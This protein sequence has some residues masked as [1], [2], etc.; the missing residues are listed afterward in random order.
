MQSTIMMKFVI[1]SAVAIQG[2]KKDSSDQEPGQ[3][4]LQESKTYLPG[5]GSLIQMLIALINFLSI[6]EKVTTVL[7]G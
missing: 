2:C 7:T 1:L 6:L 4:Q 5:N 3:E